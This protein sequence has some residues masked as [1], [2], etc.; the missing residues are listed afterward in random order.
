M[1]NRIAVN[2]RA[3]YL[4]DFGGP[5]LLMCTDLLILFPFVY[6]FMLFS[7]SLDVISASTTIAEGCFRVP[8]RQVQ[9][10]FA[11]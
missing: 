1:L 2:L 4:E 7:L 11:H 8:A 5:L 3:V 9:R 10:E 6:L